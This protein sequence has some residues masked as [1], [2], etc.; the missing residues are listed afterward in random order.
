M[1]IF[2]ERFGDRLEA[3][4]VLRRTMHS[5]RFFAKTVFR[6]AGHAGFTSVMLAC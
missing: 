1:A 2:M 3:Q 4:G 6:R 5:V